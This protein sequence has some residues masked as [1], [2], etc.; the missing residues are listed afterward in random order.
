[1]QIKP[2]TIMHIL[3]PRN[4]EW[5]EEPVNYVVLFGTDRKPLED[6]RFSN[7]RGNNLNLGAAQ[8]S[9]PKGRKFGSTGRAYIS[10]LLKTKETELKLQMI[11]QMDTA[12]FKNAIQH[13]CE[14]GDSP[15]HI[16]FIHGF[17]VSFQ[18]AA[19]CAAQLGYDLKVPGATFMYSWP[20]H[21]KAT[22]YVGDTASIENSLTY[23][24]SFMRILADQLSGQP[25]MIVAHSM[26]NRL[27][28]RWL[29]EQVT[30]R[31][32]ICALVFS[33]PDVDTDVFCT[34]TSKASEIA[35]LPTIYSSEDDVAIWWSKV[36]HGYER[37]GSSRA[38][39]KGVHAID[40]RGVSNR[41]FGHSYFYTEEALLTDKFF[42]LHHGSPP[43]A[44][45][46]LRLVSNA[47]MEYWILDV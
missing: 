32:N 33:A 29:A 12:N 24:M 19:L 44:R 30:V 34:Q 28:C 8:V 47:G 35:D 9:V 38:Q 5:I 6:D 40:V 43:K 1:M 39:V 20:S 2:A 15:K 4:E 26:G 31:P 18:N 7:E 36:L 21:E 3:R 42:M 10:R 41:E 14:T 23:F 17:N 45:P 46:R 25:I 27:I 37:A 11:E 22:G 16:L 13:F